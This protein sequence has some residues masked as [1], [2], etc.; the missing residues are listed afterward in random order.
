MLKRERWIKDAEKEAQPIFDRAKLFLR[1]AGVL[2]S[3]IERE[4]WV[5]VNRQDLI[6]DILDAGRTNGCRTIRFYR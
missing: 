5:T 3:A 4:F 6:N 1:K 2:S